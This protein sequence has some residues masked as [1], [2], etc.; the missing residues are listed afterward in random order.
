MILIVALLLLGYIVL[1]KY[2][3]Y[4]FS[5]KRVSYIMISGLL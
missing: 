4:L 2:Q 1:K 3:K 5:Y